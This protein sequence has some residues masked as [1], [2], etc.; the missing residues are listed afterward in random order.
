MQHVPQPLVRA[1]DSK[2]TSF[3]HN[4]MADAL[5]ATGGNDVNISEDQDALEGRPM[6]GTIG[7]QGPLLQ[8]FMIRKEPD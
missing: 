6:N 5:G 2:C 8:M 4:S 3:E 1:V 7:G